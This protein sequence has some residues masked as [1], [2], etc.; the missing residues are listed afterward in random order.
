MC[1]GISYSWVTQNCSIITQ[2]LHKLAPN[3]ILRNSTVTNEMLKKRDHIDTV[4]SH[5]K[6]LEKKIM[7]FIYVSFH[8]TSE[9]NCIIFIIIWNHDF[10]SWFLFYQKH[11]NKICIK[12]SHTCKIQHLFSRLILYKKGNDKH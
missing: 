5:E 6:K 4:K 7:Q 9:L 3:R 2:C 11:F 1:I 10:Y 12:I 8:I